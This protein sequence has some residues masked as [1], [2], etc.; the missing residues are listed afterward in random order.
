MGWVSGIV[1]FFL[2]WWTALFAVLPIGTR[3]NPEGDPE[4]G[5]RGVPERP[6][7]LRKVLLTTVVSAVLW[8]G[9]YVLVESEWLSFRSGWLALPEK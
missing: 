5:W 1:V 8:L 6:R 9:V 7:L 3:P 4:T 2:I